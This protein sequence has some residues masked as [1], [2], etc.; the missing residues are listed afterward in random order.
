MGGLPTTG[1][2][3]AV[4]FTDTAH[5]AFGVSMVCPGTDAIQGLPFFFP[6]TSGRPRLN[7]QGTGARAN[8]RNTVRRGSEIPLQL[9]YEA[10][11]CRLWY[12]APM[13]TDCTVMWKQATNDM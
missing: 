11:D 3:Q 12:A 1:P 10:A 9:I 5:T 2:M 13:I 4:T 6:P 8:M 7:Q